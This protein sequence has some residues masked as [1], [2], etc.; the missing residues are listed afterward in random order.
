M[1]VRPW[2]L[3]FCSIM[4]AARVGG[5]EIGKYLGPCSVVPS[6][7]SRMLY[8]AFADAKQIAFVNI[9]SGK[10]AR[11]IATPAKPTGLTLSP[12]GRELY[13]TCA[14]AQN[15]LLVMDAE[16]GK[17]KTTIPV[18]HMACGP[19]VTPDGKRLYVCNRFGNDVSVIDLKTRKEVARISATREPLATAIT[20][21]GKSVLII[22]HLPTDRAD[23]SD[24]AAVV[25]IIDTQSNATT[26]IRLPSGASG[27]RGISVSPDG[28]YAYVTHI[29]AR[30]ELPTKQVEYGWMNAN[31][32]SV[33]ETREKKLLGTVLLDEMYLGAANPWGVACTTNGKW[34]CVTHAGTHE[35]SVIDAP[36]LLKKLLAMPV[37][38]EPYQM[39]EVVYDDRNELLDYFRR[40]RATLRGK[41]AEGGELYTLG[42][43]AGVSNDLTFLAGLRRRIK[44]KGKG[45]RGLTF[46]GSKA[47]VAEY[48]TDTL[49]VVQLEPKSPNI[50]QELALGP[51]PQL[52]DR[53]RGEMLFN[54]AELCFQHW[55]SCAS[56]HP[57]ARVDGLN[58]DLINDGIGNLKNTK[59]MLLA[60]KTP[61]V[62]SS[63]VREL[64]EVAV[65]TG[66]RRILFTN[67]P[68]EDAATIDTY[69]KLLEPVPSPYLVDGQLIP[70]AK[71]GKKLFF[72]EK[73]GCSKCHAGPLYTDMQMHDVG[74]K[75]PCDRRRDFDTPTLIEVW[76]TAPYFHDG[77][78]TTVKESISKCKDHK[79]GGEVELNEQQINDLVEFVLSL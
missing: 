7:D 3:I 5:G 4:V 73:V 63:G 49:S 35:L 15:T 61:P 10:V 25:T 64:A 12:D 50:V 38:P 32:L 23:T 54:D 24:V 47:Y 68:E 65:R 46:I 76:R 1:T 37:N 52:T 77:R 31:A 21:D 30:Y 40:L 13:V 39:G 53:R 20:P 79:E 69:L 74:S 11:S 17:I 8:I 60:H 78:Y 29:L 33:I 18:G 2:V 67:P 75:S 72:S 28:K 58:W 22:N 71:R 36:A 6:S 70:I 44:L 26:T 27:L 57:E 62:M 9:H 51:K 66:L 16:S 19:T 48:F 42:S 34:I 45:P 55:Q 43:A 14:A 59:S 56:C 41:P